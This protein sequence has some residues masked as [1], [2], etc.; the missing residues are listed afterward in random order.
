[1]GILRDRVYEAR[2]HS[3][4]E[5]EWLIEVGAVEVT[6]DEADLQ[7]TETF[8]SLIE[9]HLEHFIDVGVDE[10]DV[11]VI[12]DIDPDEWIEARGG[13][14]Y[15]AYWVAHQVFK[16]PSPDALVL[17]AATEAALDELTDRW[18][19]DIPSRQRY[20]IIMALRGFH[21]ECVF[22]GGTVSLSDTP[23]DSC[24]EDYKVISV[25]CDA[26][27]RRYIEFSTQQ[28]DEDMM[29]TVSTA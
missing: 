22:C 18:D 26:C 10:T 20:R 3:V 14:D 16:W 17:D 29:G 13:D 19:E 7:L 8:E 4:D 28:T 5:A 27:G 23:V 11:G 12:F 9:K 2:Q 15:I 6:D 21:D 1:M 25:E 24:C